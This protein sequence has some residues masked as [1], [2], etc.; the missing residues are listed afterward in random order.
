MTM[1][2]QEGLLPGPEDR[3]GALHPSFQ[4]P[5]HAQALGAV[6]ALLKEGHISNA[7]WVESFSTVIKAQPQGKGESTEDAYY[8]QLLTA[9]ELLLTRADLVTPGEV[10][11]T[12]EH[13][14]RSYLNTPHGKPI[15]LSRGWPKPEGIS[16]GAHDDHDDDDYDHHH[17]DHSHG[18]LTAA[19]VTPI[20][21]DPRKT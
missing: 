4:K 21:V 9:L 11:E 20:A 19:D 10:D 18:A 15:E 6:Y 3:D 5:W 16:H 17:H 13:W 8:R 14:R 1:N 7:E 2:I 12:A